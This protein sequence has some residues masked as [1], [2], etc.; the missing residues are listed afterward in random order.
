M[1][2]LEILSSDT[3]HDDFLTRAIGAVSAR[4]DRECNRTLARTVDATQEF[5]AMDTETIARCYPIEMVS[6]F[7]LPVTNLV[8]K[9]EVV[10]AIDAMGSIINTLISI[11]H[12][13]NC[14]SAARPCGVVVS[15]ARA[16]STPCTS[17]SLTFRFLT[18]R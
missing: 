2:S 10:G 5:A 7:E 8:A 4:F 18:C 1:Y 13:T 16:V 17:A 15:T 9:P 12:F 6:K 3:T 14:A 11:S